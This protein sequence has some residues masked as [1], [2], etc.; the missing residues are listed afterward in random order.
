MISSLTGE[1]A[2]QAGFYTVMVGLTFAFVLLLPVVL[3]LVNLGGGAAIAFIEA[4]G[5]FLDAWYKYW[6]GG[7]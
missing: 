6:L 3:F 5:N 2:A 1:R 4:V 7:Q